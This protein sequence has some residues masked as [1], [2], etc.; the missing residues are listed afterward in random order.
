MSGKI[1]GAVSVAD[2]GFI[3]DNF[4]VHSTFICINQGFGY[5]F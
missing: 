2:I 5:W 3:Q 1:C 4:C